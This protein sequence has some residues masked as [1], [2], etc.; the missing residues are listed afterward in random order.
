[1]LLLFT[2]KDPLNKENY[3]PV[4]LLSLLSKVFERLLH[5]QIE[6]VMSNKLSNKLSGF[7]KNYKTQ[8]CLTCYRN[9]KW[10]IEVEKH[11]WQR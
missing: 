2:K 6:T 10:K 1:M 7:R 5:K 4:S 3:R 8:Y 11:T 9:G